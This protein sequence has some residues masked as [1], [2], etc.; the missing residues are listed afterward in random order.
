[1]RIAMTKIGRQ[2]VGTMLRKVA[3]DM[4]TQ[5]RYF[6]ELD[7]GLGD[8]DHGITVSRGW[9]ALV[10]ALPEQENTLEAMFLEL[11]DVMMDSMGGTIGPVYAMLFE[12]FG[13]AVSGQE[14]IDLQVAARMFEEGVSEIGVGADVKE[15]MKTSFDAL[16]PAARALRDAA[17]EGKSLEEGFQDAAAAAECG[18]QAT[19]DMIAGKGR[20]RFLGEG[21]VGKKDAGAASMAAMVRSMA[22]WLADRE[23]TA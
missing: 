17:R 23:G 5:E 2:D 20:A 8:G 7:L 11:G 18:A 15:G 22:M 19:V 10:E 4:I 16:A 13:N 12:G 9:K 14:E 3:L 21:S 6:C 1:M